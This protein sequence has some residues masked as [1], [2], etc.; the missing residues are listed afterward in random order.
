MIKQT[1]DTWLEGRYTG[2][3]ENSKL[4]F[5][6]IIKVA[7]AYGLKICEILNNNQLHRIPSI[8][9]SKDPILCRVNIKSGERVKPKLISG[10]SLEYME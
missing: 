2:T 3:D 8:L 6:N 1:Q 7:R 4:G 10:K 9:T 5:P